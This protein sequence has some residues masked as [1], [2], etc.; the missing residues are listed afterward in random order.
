MPVRSRFNRPVRRRRAGVVAVL[1]LALAG[2]SLVPPTL[3]DAEP[4]PG[5]HTDLSTV[6][7]HPAPDWRSYVQTPRRSD[8]CPTG[9]VSTS[10]TVTGAGN[11]LCGRA[12]GATLTMLEGGDTPTI[13]LDY[14]QEVGGLPYFVVASTA[15]SPSLKAAYS[16]G[17][18]NLTP[19]GDG[20]PPWAD[21]DPARSDVYQI[22][23]PGTITNRYVQGGE[24]YEAITLTTPG[25]L[26]LS[27]VG[28]RYIA[29]RTQADEYRGHFLSSSDEL[30]RI[31]YAGAYT[32]QTNLVPAHSL[33]GSWTVKDGAL[34]AGG[35]R[36]N[37]G[38]GILNTGSSWRDYTSTFQTKITRNQAGWMA[39]AQTAQDGYLFILNSSADTAGT[40]NTLQK[41]VLNDGDYTSL[42][43]V[44]LPHPIDQNTWHT[45]A[46]T[47][48]GSTISISLDGTPV[49]RIDTSTS[50]AGPSSH[51][52]GTV[53]FREFDGEEAA[54]RN[55]TVTG[56]DSTTLY[57]NTLATEAS[58]AAF[59]PPGSNVVP[60]VLD[61]ARR[62]RAIWSGDLLVE[63]PTDY[64]SIGN[65]EN[66]KQSLALL[67]S[68]QLSSGFIPGA[69]HPATV[70]HI[71]PPIPG[72]TTTYSA[73]YSMAF[74]VA[75]ATYYLYTGDKDFIVK[76]WPVVQRQLAWNATRIDG[77]GL[78]ATRSGIDG[79]DWDFY[80]HD[81]AGEVS[82]YNILYY[83]ALTDGATLA[84]AVGDT[85]A[86]AAHTTA[87]AALKTRINDRLYDPATGLYKISDTQV[88][89][90]AQDANILA[91]LY[92]VAPQPK[93]A[94]ILTR[95]KTSLWTTPYGPLPY[96]LDTGYRDLVSP[97]ISGFELQARLATGDTANAQNLLHS[98]WGRM[99]A[100][101]PNQTGTMWEN[102]SGTDGTP[103]LGAG[104]SLA[105]GW[106]TAP[107]SALSSYVLGARPT[108]AGYATWIVQPRPGDLAWAR[109]QV[110]T[111][112][113]PINVD[114]TAQNGA[115]R[116]SM[117][118][119]APP[120]TQGTIAVPTGGASHPTVIVN[121][122]VVWR[123]GTFAAN[124][125]VTAAW[126]DADY[127]YLTADRQSSYTVVSL[128][129]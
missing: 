66:I 23:G 80:D 119:T 29:D 43:S 118:V 62:D 5:P 94:E 22:S 82:A 104:T 49:D 64:Y 60:S 127:V 129:G 67:G 78:L 69:L 61:G 13:V 121:G 98:V 123:H 87:A 106:S 116:F 108:T 72:D 53:G 38:A 65:A 42:G 17:R 45:V 114:W 6:S 63:G 83:K 1:A 26:T 21:G 11:L 126:A 55:L 9:L 32:L 24:R 91:V 18:G 51:L 25:T 96:S 128:P 33:P 59:T 70:P 92:G 12:G 124:A 99:I 115:H 68:R 81:K 39:R 76:E 46:T 16:E 34:Q 125:G 54:F 97:Y 109:G 120:N 86:A 41:F 44:A 101:G 40:P 95:L 4:A 58:L 7:P 57:R 93:H 31:W 103:G 110:P 75:L 35:S 107:T 19:T 15:G 50:P 48:S 10:G 112:H 79:A 105:H 77:N 84:T 30:N 3:A 89:G 37:D 122:R 74:V 73:T 100:P 8:V 20:S 52:A 14:G 71:G 56:A 113:G 111:P 102:I 36:I 28:I 117:T 2:A 85:S 27:G 47:V 90:T 88:S